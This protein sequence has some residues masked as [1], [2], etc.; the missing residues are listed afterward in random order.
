MTHFPSFPLTKRN[1]KE[2]ISAHSFA[3]YLPAQFHEINRLI[4]FGLR[5]FPAPLSSKS[6]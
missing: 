3:L 1:E 4:E 2:M 6:S 5:P